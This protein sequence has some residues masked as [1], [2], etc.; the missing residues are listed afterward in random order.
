MPLDNITDN[1]I[2][3]D[4]SQIGKQAGT[5]DWSI[6]GQWASRG[7]DERYTSLREM[8][9]MMDLRSGMSNERN[10][11]LGDIIPRLTHEGSV[12]FEIEGEILEPTNYSFQQLGTEMKVPTGFFKSVLSEAPELV[13]QCLEHGRRKLDRPDQEVQLYR[14]GTNLRGVTGPKYGRI[15]D[16][17]IVRAL[18][19]ATRESGA[20]WEV[21][22][23]FAMPGTP[24][25]A[26]VDPTKD[27]TTLYASDRDVCLFL[28]DQRNPIEAGFVTDP[29]T[30]GRVPDVYSRGIIVRNGECGGV[31]LSVS[32][33]LY[34]WVCFNRSIREQKGFQ[35]V[36]LPHR[37]NVRDHFLKTMVPAMKSF[38]NGSAVGIAD[39]IQRSKDAALV[40][41][42]DDC[43]T[44]LTTTFG[45][46]PEVAR[47]IMGRSLLE[48]ARPI[49]SAFDMVQA[50]TAA[51]R[52]IR[53]QDDR[54]KIERAAGDI[55][56]KV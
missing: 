13:V 4:F 42:D 1:V 12:G 27:Q 38:V 49:R 34:R 23:A 8:L 19:E 10:V 36:S 46:G 52:G 32:T 21:P 48:D 30:G 14:S 2:T 5:T 26:C 51:A 29:E 39:E 55:L 22:T 20:L 47:T 50:M 35:K 53:Q 44:R 41:D 7:P 11:L 15:E 45:F 6:S 43:F 24:S 54:M 40:R 25:F 3:A 31:A 56:A 16:R 33:F 9:A 28:V 18:D 17:E 37:A